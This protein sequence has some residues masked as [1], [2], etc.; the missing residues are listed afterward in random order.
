MYMHGL[1]ILL[2]SRNQHIVEQLYFNK[3][4]NAF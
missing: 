3:K 4:N 1:F 2:L